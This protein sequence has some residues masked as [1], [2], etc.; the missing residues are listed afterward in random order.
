MVLSSLNSA[1]AKA[2]RA[3]AQTFSGQF[4]RGLGAEAVGVWKFDEGSGGVAS[5]STG[6]GNT[7]TLAAGTAAWSSDTFS[8]TGSSFSFNGSTYL[9]GSLPATTFA[10]DF[11]ITAWF[12]RTA[13]GTWGGIFSNNTGTPFNAPLMTMRNATTQFGMNRSGTSEEGVYVDLGS[14]MNNKWIFGVVQ[15]RGNT[16]TVIAFKDGRMLSSSA[17]WSWTLNSLSGFIIGRHYSTN[18]NF[19]GLID[20]VAVYTEA[21]QISQIEKLYGEGAVRLLAVE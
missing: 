4:A 11:T 17:T 13:N 6:L 15:R 1:R 7:G 18:H 5:D 16:V 9:S 8:G 19:T 21:L 12:K 3:A 2:Q 20:E 10:G 14:D